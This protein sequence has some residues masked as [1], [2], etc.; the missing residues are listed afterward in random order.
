MGNVT[1]THLAAVDGRVLG[2]S[3]ATVLGSPRIVPPP[4][5]LEEAR[6][7]PGRR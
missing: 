1:E 2:G 6:S 4:T 5:T 7:Q 3:V